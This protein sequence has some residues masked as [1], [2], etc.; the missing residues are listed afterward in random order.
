MLILFG[1]GMGCCDEQWRFL[2]WV[3]LGMAVSI[4]AGLFCLIEGVGYI[5]NWLYYEEDQ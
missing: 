4:T 2:F 1:L 3:V 5:V